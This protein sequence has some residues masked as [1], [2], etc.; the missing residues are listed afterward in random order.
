MAEDSEIHMIQ[1]PDPDSIGMVNTLSQV[2]EGVANSIPFPFTC[3]DLM[4]AHLKSA[5]EVALMNQKDPK[6]VRD[7]LAKGLD[8]IV[9]DIEDSKRAMN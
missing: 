9:A 1:L 8:A 4:A 2:M 6:S 3:A 5:F 7:M